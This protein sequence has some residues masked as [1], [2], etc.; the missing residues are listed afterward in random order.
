MLKRVNKG[1]GSVRSVVGMLV[2]A[3]QGVERVRYVAG[4]LKKGVNRGVER[5][6]YVAG[7]LK[8]KGESGGGE[9][10]ICSR[11]AKKRVNQGLLQVCRETKGST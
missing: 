11:D 6:R 7:M 1:V 5:V 10:E 8:K 9:G 2:M 4:I 3:N